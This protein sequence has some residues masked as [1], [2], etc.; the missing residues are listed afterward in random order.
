MKMDN[1][2]NIYE[3]HFFSVIYSTFVLWGFS[4]V[5]PCH[6]M[7]FHL[8]DAKLQHIVTVKNLMRVTVQRTIKTVI[9]DIYQDNG[10]CAGRLRLHS[11]DSFPTRACWENMRQCQL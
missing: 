5:N 1:F 7:Y 2:A 4:V 8:N 6:K 9:R 3:T 10:H 11:L